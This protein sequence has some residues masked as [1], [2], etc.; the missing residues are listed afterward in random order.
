MNGGTTEVA[1]LHSLPSPVRQGNRK[2]QW[3]SLGF[4]RIASDRVELALHS[5]AVASNGTN[6]IIKAEQR[7]FLPYP[8]AWCILAPGDI[9]EK[10]CFIQDPV[11]TSRGHGFR[12]VVAAS[13]RIFEMRST[14][15]YPDFKEILALKVQDS[16]NRWREKSGKQSPAAL[17]VRQRAEQSVFGRR[18]VAPELLE[19]QTKGEQAL[20]AKAGAVDPDPSIR[21]VLGEEVAALSSGDTSLTDRIMFWQEDPTGISVVD[22]EKEAERLRKNETEGNAPTEGDTPS[23][24]EDSGGF[25]GGIF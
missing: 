17:Q 7:K 9:V 23:I 5:G 10:T 22:A 1:A 20:L 15:G 6:G 24:D 3:W 18:D 11:P 8:D 14:D 25:L 12:E 2:D 13:F 21:E 4:E 19:G 16:L